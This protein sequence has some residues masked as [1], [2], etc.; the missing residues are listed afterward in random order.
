VVLRPHHHPK[1]DRRVAKVA[2][3]SRSRPF[4]R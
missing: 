4:T 1:D 2:R 3:F